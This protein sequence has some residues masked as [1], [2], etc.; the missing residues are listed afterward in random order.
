MTHR[1]HQD[2]DEGQSGHH[3]DLEMAD[4]RAEVR[5]HIVDPHGNIVW[6]KARDIGESFIVK[7]SP[8]TIIN[9]ATGET[10]TPSDW[11]MRMLGKYVRQKKPRVFMVF[12]EKFVPPEGTIEIK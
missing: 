8:S 5:Q 10:R 11:T 12:D 9:F 1:I 4:F 3:K 7:M 6:T 2:R